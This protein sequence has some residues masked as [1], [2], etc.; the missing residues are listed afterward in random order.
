MPLYYFAGDKAAG[1]IKGQGVRD[2]W[3]VAAP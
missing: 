3:F 1:D 2:V